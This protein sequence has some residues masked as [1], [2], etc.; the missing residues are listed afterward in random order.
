MS[1][2]CIQTL[3][4]YSSLHKGHL[5]KRSLKPRPPFEKVCWTVS[6]ITLRV[7]GQRAAACAGGV[8]VDPAAEEEGSFG[9]ASSP[10]PSSPL[11][12]CSSSY[13]YSYMSL[14]LLLFLFVPTRPPCPAF[15]YSLY[16]LLLFPLVKTPL[17]S[18][19]PTSSSSF[20]FLLLLLSLLRIQNALFCAPES[21]LFFI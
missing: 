9:A 2:W 10:S 5:W 16:V 19:C 15:P 7:R 11:P 14:L 18:P 4:C 6:G 17:L 20:K 13:Y 8:S 21:A 3:P 1:L 12:P